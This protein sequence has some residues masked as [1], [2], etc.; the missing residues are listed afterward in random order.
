MGNKNKLAK[1]AEIREFSNVFEHNEAPKGKW[2]SVFKNDNPIVLE[3]ACGKG[4]YTLGLAQLF[5]DKNFIGVDIKGNRIWRG[6]KTATDENIPNAAFLRC[7]IGRITDYFSHEE[8]S[9]IWITFADPQPRDGKAKKRLTHLNFI[10]KYIEISIKPLIINLKCDSTLLYEFTKEVIHE[11]NFKTLVDVDDVY[12][13][14]E[15][16]EELNIQT[17]YEKMWLEEGKKIKYLR[18]SVG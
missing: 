5:S 18:F 8:V 10:K 3:L 6:A 2:S 4:E 15:R 1:F 17:F 16:P 7:Q 11:N 9:E 13:W 12:N 14:D